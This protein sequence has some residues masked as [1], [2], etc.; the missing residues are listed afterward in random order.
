MAQDNPYD[1]GRFERLERRLRALEDAETIRNLKARY[2]ASAV[3]PVR[4]LHGGRRKPGD[5]A[6]QHR[7]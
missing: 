2:A 3:V 1:P 5:V 7:S 4:A 6:C